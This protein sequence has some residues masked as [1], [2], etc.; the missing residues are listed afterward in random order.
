MSR[1]SRSGHRAISNRHDSLT[2][3]FLLAEQRRDHTALFLFRLGL[4]FF[5]FAFFHAVEKPLE[6][7]HQTVELG[8]RVFLF[9]LALL[10]LVKDRFDHAGQPLD[11]ILFLGGHR[12][13]L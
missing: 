8:L 13:V 10:A 7:L 9:G 11:W 6:A 2:S 1:P 5:A 4:A 3:L 12:A